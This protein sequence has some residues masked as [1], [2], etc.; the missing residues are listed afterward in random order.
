[1][2]RDQSILYI[3]LTTSTDLVEKGVMGNPVL[4]T[5]REL[6]QRHSCFCKTKENKTEFDKI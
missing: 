5:V 2:I 3:R 6:L 1:M 4:L